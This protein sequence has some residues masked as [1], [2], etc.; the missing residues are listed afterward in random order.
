MAGWSTKYNAAKLHSTYVV[1]QTCGLS[2]H[3]ALIDGQR[4]ENDMTRD[5]RKARREARDAAK[6][7]A[8]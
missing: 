1:C 4:C 3:P 5:E 2:V 7:A 8:A 6:Q